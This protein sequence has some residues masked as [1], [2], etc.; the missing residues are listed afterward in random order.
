MESAVI[1][2]AKITITSSMAVLYATIGEIFTERSG[3]LNLGVEGMM[4]VGALTAFAATDCFQSLWVG[5]LF[6]MLISGIF[7]LIHGFFAITFRVNQVVSGLALTLFGIGL[8]D[9]LGRPFI[10]KVSL[11]FEPF[12]L[13]PLDKIPVVG[14]ILFTHSAL[15][16]PAYL[17]V[18]LAYVFLYKTRYGLQLRAVGENPSAADTVG[19]PVF[20]MRYLYTFIGGALAGL[21]GAYLS[22]AY[23]PGWK[24]QMTGGQGWIA[25]ALVIFSMWDPLKALGGALLFGFINAFQFYCQAAGLTLIPSYVLRMLPYL[26]TIVVLIVITRWEAA[27]KRVGAPA[28]LGI[29]FEREQ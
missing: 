12:G 7:A 17:L 11:K 1:F 21:G 18:P 3:V 26:F 9:F 10:G 28:A 6:A 16:Y 27:K 2:V 29:P 5:V 8:S 15:V 24:E 25:I 23:T 19:I 13:F 20:P 14:Q 4:L 22:L